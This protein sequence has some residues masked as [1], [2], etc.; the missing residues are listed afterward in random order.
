MGWD[1]E[2]VSYFYLPFLLH[3]HLVTKPNPEMFSRLTAYVSWWVH[4][5]ASCEQ[6][7]R[8]AMIRQVCFQE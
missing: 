2:G 3:T 8:G 4:M 7:S 6:L 5:V 1:P